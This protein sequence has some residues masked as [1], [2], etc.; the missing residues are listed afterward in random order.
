MLVACD[1]PSNWGR[2][3]AGGQS[4]AE[5]SPLVSVGAS[6]FSALL[7]AIGG[8]AAT[9]RKSAQGGDGERLRAQLLTLRIQ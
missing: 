1:R 2:W 8:G 7:P 5:P 3:K 9:P 4:S 6:P